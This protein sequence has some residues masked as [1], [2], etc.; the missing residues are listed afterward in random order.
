MHW[1]FRMA[2]IM[3]NRSK[4]RQKVGAVLVRKGFVSG[5]WSQEGTKSHPMVKKYTANRA[6]NSLHAEQHALIGIRPELYRGGTMYIYRARKDGEQGLAAPCPMCMHWLT[7]A[8]IKKVFYSL[9]IEGF[10]KLII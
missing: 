5:G 9:D 3:A 4:A 8:G 10:N 6:Y 1:A 7:I 2:E